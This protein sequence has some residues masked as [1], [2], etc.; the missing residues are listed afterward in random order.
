MNSFN[1]I[2]S[3]LI[4]LCACCAYCGIATA[5]DSG[6]SA[7][8]K[9]MNVPGAK[10]TLPVKVA[11]EPFD[12]EFVDEARENFSNFHMQM[13]GDH[14][15]YY[16]S[17]LTEL[18]PAALA[19]ASGP[20]SVLE[21]KPTPGLGSLTYTLG[22]GTDSQPLD[23]YVDADDTRLQGIMILHKGRVVY[24]VYPGISPE[25]LHIWA[26]VS[27]TAVGTLLTMLEA[28]G[29]VDTAKP[30]TEYVPDLKGTAWD[31]VSVINAMNMQAGLDIAETEEASMN[32]R[33]VFQ[34]VLASDFGVPNADG[35][36]E[37]TMDVLAEAVPLKGEEPGMASRY[38]SVITRTLVDVIEDATNRTFTSLFEERIWSKIGARSPAAINLTPEG[39]AIAYGLINS[40]LDDLARYALVFTPSWNVVSGEQVISPEVLEM[41]QT[42]GSRE[43]YEKGDFPGHSWVKSSFAIEGMPIFNSRQWD[44]VWAD[45]AM[46]KHGNLFQG[47]YVDPKRDVVGVYFSTSPI[48][49]VDVAPGYLREAAKLL[50]GE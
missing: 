48:T 5:Q 17:H 47:I 46:F 15:L 27:K 3:K 14:A 1:R 30:I 13:G 37:R 42:S 25:E 23:D 49:N 50:A 41:M 10:V 4:L 8:E 39:A 21:R 31:K 28:E 12:K 34:R 24:E 20:V 7:L 22:D 43:A 29:V 35:K 33:S 36:Q 40:R 19:S 11:K 38:S 2:S 16:N 45:G 18:I 9:A 6:K 26:S 44:A 32:P